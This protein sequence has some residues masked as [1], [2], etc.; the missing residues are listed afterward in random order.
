MMVWLV[1]PLTRIVPN[2]SAFRE[3]ESVSAT[4]QAALRL[5]ELARVLVRFNH[6]ANMIIHANHGMM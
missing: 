5:F 4:A 2:H 1:Y 3:A 6:V